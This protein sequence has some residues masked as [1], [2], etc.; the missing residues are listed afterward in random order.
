MRGFLGKN[1]PLSES[2]KTDLFIASIHQA[3]DMWGEGIFEAA[4]WVAPMPKVGGVLGKGGRWLVKV[5]SKTKATGQMH[6]LLSNKIM[7]QLGKHPN[8]KGVFNRENPTYKYR[9][10]NEQAHRGYQRWPRE[11]DK[12]VVNWLRSNPNATA[13]EFKNYLN[14]IHQEVGLSLVYPM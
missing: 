7:R 5:S 12:K 1:S 8:L 4:M 9:T 11:Y 2:A 3:T 10:L 6:H 13:A 14:S